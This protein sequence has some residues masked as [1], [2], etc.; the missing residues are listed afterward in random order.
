[1]LLAVALIEAAR[2]EFELEEVPRFEGGDLELPVW[3]GSVG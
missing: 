3:L 1:V 2:P